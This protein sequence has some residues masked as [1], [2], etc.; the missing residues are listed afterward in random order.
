MLYQIL[1][2]KEQVSK[3]TP[4]RGVIN[5]KVVISSVGRF[6]FD[7]ARQLNR[8]GY[9]E[10]I[11]TGYPMWKVDDDLREKTSSFPWVVTPQ[12]AL[13]R[14]GYQNIAD[15][16]SLPA[17]HTLDHWVA[18]RLP[19]CD[20]FVG[21]SQSG[22]YTIR[23]AK[24][25]G[26]KTVCER[27]SS[28]IV[29]QNEILIEEHQRQNIPFK[30]IAQWAIEKEL[31]EY[32]EADLIK[33]PSTFAYETFIQHQVPKQKLVIVP[34]GADLR[35]FH[36]LSKEDRTFRILYAGMMSARKGVVYLLQAMANVKY[37]DVETLLLGS[38]L[39]EF[40]PALRKYAGAFRYGGVVPRAKL[41]W[42]YSQASVFV[43]PS[44]EEGLATVMAQAMAC[45]V[46]VI[47]TA[48]SGAKDL[49]TD[50]VEGFIVPIRA[51]DAIQEKIQF[52]YEN[53]IIR[54]QMAHAALRRVQSM[55]GWDEH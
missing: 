55:G 29:A 18:S 15:R 38:I 1:F 35:L 46:P 44:V 28:H 33:V 7:L 50:G 48:N 23:A 34:L 24:K 49:F 2:Q 47:A 31:Q 54:E 9:L 36:P 37:P 16:L 53:P 26:I 3:S 14:Y 11:F 43:M 41:S 42:Y 20:V 27:S 8:M 32:A 51:P 12:M 19:N 10:R 22:L 13:Y 40:R 30:G 6:R 21:L 17:T 45:G 4:A 52:L 25:R 39:N 5:L